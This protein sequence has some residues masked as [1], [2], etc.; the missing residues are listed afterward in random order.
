MPQDVE[1]TLFRPLGWDACKLR[2]DTPQRLE[3]ELREAGWQVAGLNSVLRN[4]L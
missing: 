1:A 4:Y 2:P 3:R